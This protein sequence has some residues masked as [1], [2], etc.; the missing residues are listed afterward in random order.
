MIVGGGLMNMQTVKSRDGKLI[1]H[2]TVTWKKGD[3]FGFIPY[4]RGSDKEWWCKLDYWD[5][6]EGGIPLYRLK[7]SS[8]MLP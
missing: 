4:R 3:E 7:V 2:G 1:F 5:L 8:S 6:I